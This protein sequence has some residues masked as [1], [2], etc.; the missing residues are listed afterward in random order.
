MYFKMVNHHKR[1][2]TITLYR[3][4]QFFTPSQQHFLSFLSPALQGT[5]IH[6]IEDIMIVLIIEKKS[7]RKI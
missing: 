3:F 4:E 1:S 7:L 6:S 2:L 5:V